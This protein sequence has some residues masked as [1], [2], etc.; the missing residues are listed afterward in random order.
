MLFI[1]N[2]VSSVKSE[3]YLLDLWWRD[4]NVLVKR[5]LHY[6]IFQPS[7]TVLVD[8]AQK[9]KLDVDRLGYN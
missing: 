7:G 5:F 9:Q 2:Q 1:Y 3:W 8:I 6:R 4:Q